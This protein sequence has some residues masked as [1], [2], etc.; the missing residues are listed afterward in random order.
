MISYFGPIYINNRVIVA[1]LRLEN[2][3]GYGTGIHHRAK[4]LID[5]TTRS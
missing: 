5:A 2:N 3:I 4:Q 1:S